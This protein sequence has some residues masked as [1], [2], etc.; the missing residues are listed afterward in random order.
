[1]FSLESSLKF[2]KN[3]EIIFNLSNKPNDKIAINAKG[4]S[5][6]FCFI[7]FYQQWKVTLKSMCKIFP[8]IC[9]QMRDFNFQMK[10]FLKEQIIVQSN[11]CIVFAK[12]V[13]LVFVLD[14]FLPGFRQL[15]RLFIVLYY[16]DIVYVLITF[17]QMYFFLR[18]CVQ[19]KLDEQWPDF[20]CEGIKVQHAAV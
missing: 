16:V 14:F 17:L 8:Y 4:S 9:S 5:Q 12:S 7:H 18:E 6:G 2:L 11:F 1:M 15:G 3:L 20:G 13:L 19:Q 10:Q